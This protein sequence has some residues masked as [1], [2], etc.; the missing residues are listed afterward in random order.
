MRDQVELRFPAWCKVA[1]PVTVG[2][3]SGVILSWAVWSR[4]FGLAAWLA[5]ATVLVLVAA[6]IHKRSM[7]VIVTSSDVVE[8]DLL[9]QRV[10]PLGQLERVRLF[11]NKRLWLY[12]RGAQKPVWVL[13]G[14][15]EPRAVLDLVVSRA[16]AHG[17]KP[18]IV[19]TD[20]T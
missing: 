6:E 19:V 3:V 12:F 11:R 15:G 1:A 13:R 9:G 4:G 16:Q 14:M 2:L 8:R 18:E 7:A 10:F 20:K 17:V 5:I